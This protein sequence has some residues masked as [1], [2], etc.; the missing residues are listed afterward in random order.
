VSPA[1]HPASSRS[2]HI[3]VALWASTGLSAGLTIYLSLG[4]IPAGAGAFPHS[5]KVWHALFY[6]VTAFLF[7]LAAVWRPGRG[8]GPFPRAGLVFLGAVLVAGAVIEVLQGVVT[9]LRKPELLDWLAE[10]L[11]VIVALVALTLLRRSD[12]ARA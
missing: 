8:Q 12:E 1:G 5:D 4:P 9:E 6:A 10:V 11:G 2:R 3:D 7:L